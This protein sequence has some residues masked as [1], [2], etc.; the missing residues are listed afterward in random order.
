MNVFGPPLAIHGSRKSDIIVFAFLACGAFWLAWLAFQQTG[1]DKTAGRYEAAICVAIGIPLATLASWNSQRR[2]VLYA[3]GLSYSNLL[4]ER[5][6]RW[7]SVRRLYYQATKMSVNFIPVG[8][9]YWIRIIDDRGQK[10]RFGSGLVK[11]A[12]LATKVLELAQGPLLNRIA[13][14]FGAGA[15]IEFGPVRVNRESGI[16]IKKLWGRTKHIPWNEVHSYRIERGSIYI[17][18]TGE[19][20]VAG[21]P[22]SKVPNAFALLAL[23]NIIFAPAEA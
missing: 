9:V 7:D 11:A 18:R 22:I 6:V 21:I 8:T 3:E 13:T 20:R 10:I 14:E 2:V 15:D 17:W 19:K 1:D 5:Q 16:V 23:L 4:G 12:L